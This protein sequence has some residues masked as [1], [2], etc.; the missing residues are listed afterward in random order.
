MSDFAIIGSVSS[1]RSS[2]PLPST[3][4]TFRADH[5]VSS[6]PD[7]DSAELSAVARYLHRLRGLPAVRAD[8]VATVRGQIIG[9]SYVT[10]PKLD[11]AIEEIMAELDEF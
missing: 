2:D 11:T 3:N 8:L 10:A 9:G 1:A 5:T 7:N 6:T 4:S